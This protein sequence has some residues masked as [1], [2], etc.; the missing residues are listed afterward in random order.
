MFLSTGKV[1]KNK[2][3]EIG[4]RTILTLIEMFWKLKIPFHILKIFGKKLNLNLR[5][6]YMISKNNFVIA[7]VSA[8]LDGV[9]I[10]FVPRFV[11][12]QSLTF[13]S[14]KKNLI[15][16]SGNSFYNNLSI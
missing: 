8:L 6:F 10:I 12:K 2:E 5:L 3:K 7:T 9:N 15:T 4:K 14:R 1:L 16:F 11:F 13:L